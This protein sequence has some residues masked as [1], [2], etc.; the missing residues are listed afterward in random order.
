MSSFR[1]RPYAAVCL[2]LWCIATP[3]QSQ[4]P[5]DRVVSPDVQADGSVIFR[6]NAPGADSA[7]VRGTFADGMIANVEMTKNDAGVFEAHFGPIAS[8]M[9]VYTFGCR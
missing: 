8:D 9:Y 4:R 3:L 6:L 5:A 1:T 2:A 7:R